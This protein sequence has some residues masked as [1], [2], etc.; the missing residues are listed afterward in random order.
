VVAACE[1]NTLYV[2][3]ARGIA[4]Y[5]L[6]SGSLRKTLT[7]PPSAGAVF[8]PALYDDGDLV[9]PGL[10]L[11]DKDSMTRQPASR[12]LRGSAIGYRQ[13]PAKDGDTASPLLTD[14]LT[15]G[16]RD[17]S[18]TCT[19]VSLD[20]VT[21]PR[22][23]WLACQ[24]AS[25][26]VGVYSRT[27]DLTRRISVRSPGFRDDGTTVG[28]DA[29]ITARIQWS[30][31]NSSVIWCA[32]FGDYVA[33]VHFTFAEGEWQPGLA[34]TPRPLMNVHRLDGTPLV[35]DLAL[36]DLPVARDEDS[37]YVLVYGDARRTNGGLR[38]EM[39]R[40]LIL[41]SAG[42]LNPALSR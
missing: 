9:L 35:A 30:Q 18:G 15:E 10:W 22:A 41:D 27:G 17:L 4:G 31:R 32:A 3:H 21:K 7:K 14:L 42:G 29:P 28:L 26:H 34:M 6:Q 2:A 33:T 24:G 19:R 39:D 25:D 8:G 1:V 11:S 16:C 23:G 13:H 38:L 20:R 5:D 12:V 37:L 36:R 40:V